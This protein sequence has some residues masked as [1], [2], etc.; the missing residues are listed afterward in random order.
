VALLSCGITKSA[1]LK[2]LP[3]FIFLH[4]LLFWFKL[5]GLKS[6]CKRA[7]NGAAAKERKKD[8]RKYPH[9]VFHARP[10]VFRDRSVLYHIQFS[11]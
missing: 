3:G 7:V 4:R 5:I 10:I 2:F 6:P 9:A 8:C 11:L 1:D